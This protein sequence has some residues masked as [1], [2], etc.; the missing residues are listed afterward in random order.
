M[1]FLFIIFLSV[2][3]FL[4][5]RKGSGAEFKNWLHLDPLRTLVFAHFVLQLIQHIIKNCGL[6]PPVCEAARFF[7][8]QGPQS[9]FSQTHPKGSNLTHFA[10]RDFSTTIFLGPRDPPPGWDPRPPLDGSQPAP[11]SRG[12][13]VF[14]KKPAPGMQQFK[15]SAKI[16]NFFRSTIGKWQINR[17]KFRTPEHGNISFKAIW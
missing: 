4:V 5:R 2:L 14:N 8:P 7:F 12:G 9:F 6:F 10:K 11:P 13:G 16:P 15:V 17:E 1:S 3:L